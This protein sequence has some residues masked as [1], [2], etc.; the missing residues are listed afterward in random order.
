MRYLFALFIVV[1]VIEMWILIRVGSLIGAWPTISLVLLTALAGVTLLRREG[2]KT[3]ARGTAKMNRGEMP[4]QEMLE[5]LVLAV[6]GTLLLTPGFAT[7]FLGFLGLIPW[8]RRWAIRK[9]L[10]SGRFVQAGFPQGDI[11][12]A[13]GSD[14]E[15]V[16]DAE[17]WK[18]EKK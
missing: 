9:L 3:L 15:R 12:R 10:A 17:F 5:G 2:F 8:T 13:T 16:I 14:R 18:E 4:A 6:S 11:H 1:P 7:D